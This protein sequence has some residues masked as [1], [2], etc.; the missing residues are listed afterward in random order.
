VYSSLI[1]RVRLHLPD[2]ARPHLINRLDR[3]TSGLVLIAKSPC[4]A[5]E[6]CHIWERRLVQKHYLAIVNGH[7]RESSGIIDAPLGKDERSSVAIKDKVRENGASAST[8]FVVLY[9]FAREDR[10][11]SLLRVEPLTGRKHQI[12]IHL[13]HYGHPIVGDKLYGDDETLYLAFVQRRLTETQRHKLILANHALHAQA[14]RFAWRGQD[15]SFQVR[16]EAWFSDFVLQSV[17]EGW[18]DQDGLLKPVLHT[19][20]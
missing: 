16:P 2:G 9:R 12:R 20:V 5:L 10:D 11:F 7:V 17:S 1:S 18:K 8:T 3:E 6:L 15:F 4:A 19:L 13:A 14:V